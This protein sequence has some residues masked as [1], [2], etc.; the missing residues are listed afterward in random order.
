MLTAF[1][2]R[3]V[4]FYQTVCHNV[5]ED[6]LFR[7]ASFEGGIRVELPE[8]YVQ[9]RVPVVGIETSSSAARERACSVGSVT[10]RLVKAMLVYEG[11]WAATPRRPALCP[12]SQREVGRMSV[13]LLAV[14]ASAIGGVR[15]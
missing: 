9:W 15:V 2:I 3:S 11:V 6:S 1:G 4:H 10:S 5:P 12:K 14:V 13:K 7:E 8:D